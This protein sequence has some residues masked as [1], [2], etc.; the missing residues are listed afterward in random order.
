MA[1]AMLVR[2]EE[3]GSDAGP[4]RWPATSAPHVKVTYLP[5]PRPS[6]MKILIRLS[7]LFAF[8]IVPFH[9]GRLT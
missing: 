1:P 6:P 5:M 7:T 4:L 9:H 3:H 2:V 8:A